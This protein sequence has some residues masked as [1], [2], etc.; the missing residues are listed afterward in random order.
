[1]QEPC[2]VVGL[3]RSRTAWMAAWLD[4]PHELL[5]G[6]HSEADF[7][8]RCSEGTSDNGLMWFPIR[9]Y[10]PNA[11]V[12]VIKRDIA[13]V[14]KSLTKVFGEL[15]KNVIKLVQDSEK[16]MLEIEDVLYVDFD[17]IDDNL[18]VIWKHLKRSEFDFR[19]AAMFKNLKI[20][21]KEI[22]GDE[23]S[24]AAFVR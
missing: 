19:R 2:F 20:E 15:P 16:R 21:L 10:Y 22:T 4:I 6:C 7:L 11:P 3:P 12:V 1:M 13:D 18:E 24:L 8:I 14:L 9:K 5:N 23:Q 17:K